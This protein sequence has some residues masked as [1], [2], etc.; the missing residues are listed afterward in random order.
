MIFICHKSHAY[1]LP[2][3]INQHGEYIGLVGKKKVFGNDGFIH[4]NPG[5]FV[6]CG[7]YIK[8]SSTIPDILHQFYSETGHQ[9]TTEQVTH[10]VCGNKAVILFCDVTENKTPTVLNSSSPKKQLVSLHWR[11]FS[12]LRDMFAN[13]HKLNKW[14]HQNYLYLAMLRRNKLIPKFEF[15]NFDDY[16]AE[17]TINHPADFVLKETICHNS[18]KFESLVLDYLKEYCAS[19]SHTNWF[20]VGMKLFCY[21]QNKP[22][23]SNRRIGF[24]LL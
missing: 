24:H 15:M 8:K 16:L 20:H 6:I 2:Y 23:I 3:Y 1:V 11:K 13:P 18:Q 19:K 12:I 9:L 7:G 5:Q 21:N 14:E 4:N 22:P 10:T 17:K